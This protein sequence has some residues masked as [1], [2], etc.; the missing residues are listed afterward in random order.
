MRAVDSHTGTV[1]PLRRSD[2]DT[3]QIAPARFVPYFARRGFTNILFAD[4][5]ADPGF[6]LNLPQHQGASILVAG[7]DFGTGSS[8][9]SAVWAL[10]AAGFRAVLAPRFGDIFRGNALAK[11]L[12]AL[13]LPTTEIELLWDAAE[14]DP[15]LEVEIDVAAGRIAYA[16]RELRFDLDDAVR[17]RLLDGSD[18]IDETLRHEDDIAAF[19]QR[20][21]PRAVAR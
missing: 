7:R 14:A 2:V 17:R 20:L 9:E 11:G 5:R 19:E 18:L 15:W 6:V 16:G 8:R 21:R 12:L 4:W 1:M 3:D 10:Q 13:A